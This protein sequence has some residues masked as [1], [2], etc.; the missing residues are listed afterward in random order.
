MRLMV[1]INPCTDRAVDPKDCERIL[2]TDV[3]FILMMDLRHEKFE[4]NLV[5]IRFKDNSGEVYERSMLRD[6]SNFLFPWECAWDREMVVDAFDDEIFCWSTC[7][8]WNNRPTPDIKAVVAD[9][10][11]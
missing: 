9:L 4:D 7:G 2:Y 5:N 6:K 8:V 11:G 10:F 3:Q 1:M